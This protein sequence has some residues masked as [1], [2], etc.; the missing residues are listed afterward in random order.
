MV[1][2]HEGIVQ[3]RTCDY[4]TGNLGIMSTQP[5]IMKGLNTHRNMNG[6]DRVCSLGCEIQ[7]PSEIFLLKKG[8]EIFCRF[9]A[10]VEAE[11]NLAIIN[12]IYM[13]RG[14]T[15]DHLRRLSE[16]VTTSVRGKFIRDWCLPRSGRVSPVARWCRGVHRGKEG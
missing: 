4:T 2:E 5:D 1:Q 7:L 12:L 9:G 6:L 13:F 8:W 14:L 11:D 10:A 15:R 16:G 3:R